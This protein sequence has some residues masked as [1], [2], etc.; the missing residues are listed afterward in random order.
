[1]EGIWKTD[2][3]APLLLFA[4]P[5]EAT[6]SNHYA[7]GIPKLAALVLKHDANAE[8]RGLDDFKGAHP[9]V[10]PVFYGFRLMVGTGMLMLA[11]SW[12][13]LWLYRRR[14]WAAG[15]L[16]RPL[17]WGLAG[18][19]FSGWLATVAGWCVT[20]NGRQ[21]FIVFG[22]IRVDEVASVVSTPMIA[23][24]LALY[25]TVYLALIVAFVAIVKYM[26]EKPVDVSISERPVPGATRGATP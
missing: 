18:M 14:G 5:D 3:G 8:L 10:K 16:P 15:Q 2:R 26:A 17:L 22:L 7:L 24:R 12:G 23:L 6:R 19:T 4:V 25:V 13:G 9:P 20:E 21:P 11:F 1:M